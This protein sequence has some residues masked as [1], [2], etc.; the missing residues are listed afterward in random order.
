MRGM[1]QGIT[2]GILGR[3]RWIVFSAVCAGVIAGAV[4]SMIH[5]L[6]MVPLIR[7]AE[8]YE[9]AAAFVTDAGS[10]A[11]ASVA[12]NSGHASATHEH[13]AAEGHGPSYA[14]RAVLTL[15]T[16]L[17]A[18]IGFALLLAAGLTLRGGQVSAGAGAAWG[19]AGF[20][21]MSLAPAIGL[22]PELPGAEAAPLLARQVWWLATAAATAAGLALLAFGYRLALAILGLVLIVLP[23]LLGAPHLPAHASPVP[24]ELTRLF[25]AAAMVTNLVFWLLL[26]LA[27][28]YFLRRFAPVGTTHP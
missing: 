24:V 8:V 9:A 1:M 2:Q 21:A 7:Q 28:V 17:L 10:P 25:V 4:M 13:G 16:D 23:H 5:H 14:E 18:G 20:A 26:G 19:I 27:C 22:P 11:V 12:A 6:V 3:F 15:L